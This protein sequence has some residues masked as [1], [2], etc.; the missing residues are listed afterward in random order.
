MGIVARQSIS[1]LFSTYFGFIFGALNVLFLYPKF[2]T[3]EYY[4][5]VTFLLSASNLIWPFM[6]FGAQNT[7]VKFFTSYQHKQEQDQLLSLSLLVPLLFGS[8]LG[9]L[10]YFSFEFIANYFEGSSVIVQKHAWLIIVIAIS[11]A[12][13]E[14]FFAWCKVFMKST[15]GNLMK[16]VFHRLVIAILLLILYFDWISLDTF[17]YALVSLYFLRTFIVMGYAFRIYFPKLC[18]KFPNNKLNLIKYS[19]LIFIAGTVSV[20]LFDL[21]KTMIERF[22]PLGD[23]ATYGIGVYIAAVIGVPQRAMHQITY[24]LTANFLNTN[25][26]EDLHILYKK[27]SI[28]LLTISGLIFCLIVVNIQ[29]LYMLIDDSYRAGVV[30]VILLGVEKLYQNLLANNNSILFN[31]DYYRFV[32]ILGVIIVVIAVILN[33]I[34]IPIYGI[35]GAAYATFI[36]YFLYNTVKLVFVQFKFNMTPFSNSTLAVTG[37]ILSLSFGFYFW[38]F[39]FHSVLNIALKTILLST[40][41][42]FVVLRFNF[43]DD[44]TKLVSTFFNQIKNFKF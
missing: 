33:L 30:I 26:K 41:Y 19:F 10:G 42:L 24:P 5:L 25:N 12:Y 23:V 13:F 44:L 29:Q 11:I 1:N 15:F 38:E 35:Y 43:S 21:D 34:M 36:A 16:E 22:L 27:S 17:I 37:L 3:Q 4:G 18:F 20:F 2:L 39:P 28:T 14:I 9:L 7:L 40:I 32:L 8:A 6:A 31:S